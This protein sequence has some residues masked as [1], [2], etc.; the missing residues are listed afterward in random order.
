MTTT[1]HTQDASPRSFAQGFEVV[2]RIQGFC[3]GAEWSAEYV[4]RV[5]HQAQ[6]QALGE[7]AG[8]REHHGETAAWVYAFTVRSVLDRFE[9]GA[10]ELRKTATVRRQRDLPPAEKVARALLAAL[11][12]KA[13]VTSSGGRLATKLVK[14]VKAGTAAFKGEGP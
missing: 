14:A 10:G 7:L 12:G 5:I 13:R 11:E 4:D 9:L 8:I 6:R 2:G 3:Q 1:V